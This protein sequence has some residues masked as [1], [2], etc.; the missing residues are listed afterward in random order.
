MSELRYTDLFATARPRATSN[1]VRGLV[2]DMTVR[3]PAAC[4]GRGA[5]VR[6]LRRASCIGDLDDLKHLRPT[7]FYWP[8]VRI[9]ARGRAVQRAIAA[10]V[11]DPHPVCGNVPNKGARTDGGRGRE[12]ALCDVYPRLR[13]QR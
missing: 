11:K 8:A 6:Q 12:I 9:M 7:S 2:Y 3:A 1:G 5:V 4:A 10:Q 13:P